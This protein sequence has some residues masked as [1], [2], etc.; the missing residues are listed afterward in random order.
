[1]YGKRVTQDNEIN[2]KAVRFPENC[3]AVKI[4]V[5]DVHINCARR[6]AKIFSLVIARD[7]QD[8]FLSSFL[9]F[10][11]SCLLAF[12]GHTWSEWRF[13]G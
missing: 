8:S 4:T 1:M 12:E 7:C 3:M 11:F 13:P 5:F 10:F 9:S 2:R 6:C